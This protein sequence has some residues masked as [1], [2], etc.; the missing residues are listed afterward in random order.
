M[1][2]LVFGVKNGN[3]AFDEYHDRWHHYGWTEVPKPFPVENATDKPDTSRD[4]PK[5][6]TVR[7]AAQL[8]AASLKRDILP[9]GQILPTGKGVTAA[10]CTVDTGTETV[11]SPAT[12]KHR[13][14][15]NGTAPIPTRLFRPDDRSTTPTCVAKSR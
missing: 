15:D 7:A 5:Q 9:A 12:K 10:K 8:K 4:I 1:L 3:R 13:K 6:D 14:P 2:R 11:N